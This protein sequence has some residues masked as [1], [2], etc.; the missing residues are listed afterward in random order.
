M[1]GVLCKALIKG[2]SL[3]TSIG[4]AQGQAQGKEIKITSLTSPGQ[5]AQTSL[6]AAQAS[7]HTK[8]TERTESNRFRPG[9]RVQGELTDRGR[10]GTHEGLSALR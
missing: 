7:G 5:G 10:G 4:K 6:G 8:R 1:D 9:F 3:L 2:F